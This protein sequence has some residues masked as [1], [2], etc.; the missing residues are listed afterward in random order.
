MGEVPNNLVPAQ[1]RSWRRTKKWIVWGDSH[2]HAEVIKP[3]H[4]SGAEAGRQ[5]P[6]ALVEDIVSGHKVGQVTDTIPLFG[7]RIYPCHL[8]YLINENKP[9]VLWLDKDQE[10]NVRKQ[11]LQLESV[12]NQPVRVV[13]TDKDPKSY[14]TE[15]IMKV[16][17]G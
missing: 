6:I 16:I 14:T 9:V 2:K 17:Y 5:H 1:D 8:Y 15:Q 13:I 3:V 7:T 12:I 4:A 11:A 10:H